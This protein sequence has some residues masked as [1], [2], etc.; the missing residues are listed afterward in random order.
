MSP[1]EMLPG[2]MSPWQIKSVQDV[3][4][5]LLL[6]YGQNGVSNSWDIRWG[7]F[8]LL[9]LLGKVKPTPSSTG[10]ELQTMNLAW[11]NWSMSEK[12]LSNTFGIQENKNEK[13][14]LFQKRVKK[15]S[16]PQRNLVKILF[17]PKTFVSEKRWLSFSCIGNST[18]IHLV[19]END[20]NHKQSKLWQTYFVLSFKSNNHEMEQ[21]STEYMIL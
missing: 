13:K 12:N 21:N 3:S 7:F 11:Q 16:C 2:Q 17:C 19:L 8:L 6:K 20:R 1:R 18:P 4:R 14:Y 10:T 5:Y 9:S 15:V